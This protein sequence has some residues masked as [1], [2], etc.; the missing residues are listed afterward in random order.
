[1]EIYQFNCLSDNFGVLIRDPV[2][3]LVAAIDAP[4]EAAVRAALTQTGW[5]LTHILVTHSHHDHIDG[6]PALV[7]AFGCKVIA[8]KKAASALPAADRYV[9]EGDTVEIGGLKAA[10]WETPGHCPDHVIY[11]F[12]AEQVV[13]AGDV[14]FAL[15]CG[16]V[17]DN[18]Y[19]AMWQ[20][21]HRLSA[22]PEA[23]RVYFGH[24]YTIANGRFALAVD[25]ANPALAAEVARAAEA[26]ATGKP[27][28]P[29]TIGR[30]LA[31]NPFLRA[32]DPAFAAALGMAG[33]PAAAVFRE[34][35]ER[36]NR[37]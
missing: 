9:S 31:A 18:A 2:S 34:V 32:A 8:P 17:F 25:A 29:T 1:M 10:V 6:I 13:F 21:L 37:F 5:T 14:L 28:S 20:A 3:G 15:G 35:R 19:D 36:K 11:H 30:E 22:L 4:E 16:R 27:T 26:R 24:E 12:A 23:T 33:A 7:A